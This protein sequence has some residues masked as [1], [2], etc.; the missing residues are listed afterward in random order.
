MI[1]GSILSAPEG[2]NLIEAYIE[3]ELIGTGTV[4]G[5]DF[6]ITLDPGNETYLGKT[7]IF[8]IAGYESK[9]K[10]TFVAED[11]QTDYKLFFPQYIP[12]TSTP[13]PVPAATA[14]EIIL[15]PLVRSPVE[16]VNERLPDP[17]VLST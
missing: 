6:S 4:N 16:S 11:F 1:F 17:S 7:V 12:P 14:E 8:Q 5:S 13:T 3:D 10:Y 2:V 15:I 9:T